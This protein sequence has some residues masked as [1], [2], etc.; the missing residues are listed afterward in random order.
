MPS[1]LKSVILGNSYNLGMLNGL[2]CFR[3]E[4]IC[5][6]CGLYTLA[7]REIMEYLDFI[8]RYT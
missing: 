5:Y 8:D 3:K 1:N 4:E 7:S 2:V 6:M